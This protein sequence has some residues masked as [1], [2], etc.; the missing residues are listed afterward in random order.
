LFV[1]LMVFCATLSNISVI[2]WRSVLLSCTIQHNFYVK[3]FIKKI[4]HIKYLFFIFMIQ[5]SL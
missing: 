3:I 5:F 2:S 1:C 4:L